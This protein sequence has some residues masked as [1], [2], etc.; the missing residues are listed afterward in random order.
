MGLLIESSHVIMDNVWVWRAHYD[1]HGI[2]YDSF[3]PVQIGVFVKG[4]HVIGYDV[5]SEHTL[6]N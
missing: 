5:A 3:N 4:D 1:A 6:Q 2:V